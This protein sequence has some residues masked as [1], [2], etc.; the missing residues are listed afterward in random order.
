MRLIIIYK[1]Q[2]PLH[3]LKRGI[4]SLDGASMKKIGLLIIALVLS[5][6]A[7]QEMIRVRQMDIHNV[8]ISN[9]RDGEYVGSFSYGGF[10]YRVKTIVNSHRIMDIEILQNRNTKH[11]ERA[12]GVVAEIIKKQTPAVDAISGATTT[13]KAIMKAVENSL[14]NNKSN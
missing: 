12:E 7:S 5:G 9:I 14:F 1:L 3:R 10:E 11:A 2:A 4:R 6:C 13:S 8:D